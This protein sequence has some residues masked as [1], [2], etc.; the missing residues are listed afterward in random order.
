MPTVLKKTVLFVCG[1]HPWKRTFCL[2]EANR[3]SV[4]QIQQVA[5]QT[6]LPPFPPGQFVVVENTKDL[7][8]ALFKFKDATGCRNTASIN[9]SRLPRPIQE[10]K[11][12]QTFIR[13]PNNLRVGFQ[14]LFGH[15]QSYSVRDGQIQIDHHLP[16]VTTEEASEHQRTS[17]L[18]NGLVAHFGR[19]YDIIMGSGHDASH[20]CP[21][22]GGG[23]VQVF[24]HK[25]G[26]VVAAE[27]EAVPV[28]SDPNVT[29]PREGEYRCISF[30]NKGIQAAQPAQAVTLQL[31]A[32][33]VL[34]SS[35][36]LARNITSNP[37]DAESIN[38]ISCFGVQ[39]GVSCPLKLL[40]LSIDFENC[41]MIFK[42]LFH[43]PRC[44]LYGAYVDISINY[45]FQAL[46]L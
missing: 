37:N 10:H 14:Y 43:I 3:I 38:V 7:Q 31:Q 40:K 24:K 18:V 26:V 21:F 16:Q 9:H 2:P 25:S 12:P 5:A 39:M 44:A 15:D 11:P 36:L 29:P 27:A 19:E 46:R 6:T 22:T 41:T 30:E 35:N 1:R 45:A 34:L 8:V 13:E 33:M 28:A 23:D 4:E 32:D 42:E 20:F 17:V